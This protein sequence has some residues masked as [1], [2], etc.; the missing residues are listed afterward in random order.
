MIFVTVGSMFP[1][2]R[3]IR[4]MDDWASQRQSSRSSPRSVAENM[5]RGICAGN[6]LSRLMIIRSGAVLSGDCC[7]C[8]DRRTA[9]EFRNS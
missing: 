9:S 2:E 6:A 3:T 5:N 4:S 8:W 7:P 1:F